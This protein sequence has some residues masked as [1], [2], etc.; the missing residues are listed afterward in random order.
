MDMIEVRASDMVG[1]ALDWAVAKA[2]GVEVGMVCP[3]VID[4]NN[5]PA[6]LL[7]KARWLS[8]HEPARFWS[9]ST[10]WSQGGPLIAKFCV[11]LQHLG[12]GSVLAQIVEEGMTEVGQDALQAACRV[13]VAAKFGDVVHVSAELVKQ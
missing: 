8:G 10:D 11:D 3:P 6:I 7:N 4:E 1:P 12:D 13:I 5:Q 2:D 9:P